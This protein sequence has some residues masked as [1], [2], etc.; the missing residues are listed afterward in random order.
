MEKR[1]AKDPVLEAEVVRRIGK[2]RKDPA[3]VEVGTK[4]T[5]GGRIRVSSRT[6]GISFER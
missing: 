5:G 1:G 4:R 3:E 6:I 2:R